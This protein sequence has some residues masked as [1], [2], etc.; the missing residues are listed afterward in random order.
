MGALV[1]L[2]QT[3]LAWRFFAR[4][5]QAGGTWDIIKWWEVRR[6]P[7]NF[8]VGSTGVFT[9]IVFFAVVAIEEKVF[10]P[11]VGSFFLIPIGVVAYGFMANVCYT[12]G[13]LAEIAV[14]K[15]WKDRAG[16]FGE[17][18]FALGLIFSVLLTL[19][20]AALVIVALILRLL[21]R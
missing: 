8:I 21:F 18:A 20:P 10:G 12:G 9:L 3:I 15:I 14:G 7:Y 16:A 13:W 6:I 11:N 5:E 1:K 17:I 19:V 4:Q 2:V